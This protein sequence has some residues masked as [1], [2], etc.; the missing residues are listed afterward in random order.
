MIFPLS[1]DLFQTMNL[2]FLTN[3]CS[4]IKQSCRIIFDTKS[5]HSYHRSGWS[6]FY[7][8]LLYNLRL[9]Q[10]KWSFLRM[11][12]GSFGLPTKEPYTIRL[13][14]SSL[15]SSLASALALSAL[16]SSVHTSPWHRVRQKLRIW[17][18]CAQMSI[19]GSEGCRWCMPPNRI[20][21]FC[22]TYIFAKKCLRQRSAPP[23]AQQP[24]PMG[25]PGST[26]V[27]PPHM[28]I[29]LICSF[30]MA[31]VLVFFFDLLSCVH[32]WS[33][34]LYIYYEYVH[35]PTYADYIFG[36]SIL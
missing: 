34:K 31:A 23:M 14:P 18:T 36:Y 25:N 22:F 29:N 28:H 6:S 19:G 8:N 21:F 26:T 2:N 7:F 32:R 33:Q 3:Y 20:Q 30:Q 27:C 17:Y 1:N 5:L 16:V 9:I 24:P 11:I 10:K 35:M 15:A 4:L 13:C 12:F